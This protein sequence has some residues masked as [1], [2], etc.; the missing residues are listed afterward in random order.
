MFRSLRGVLFPLLFAT[1]TLHAQSNVTIAPQIGPATG[2]QE[3][4]VKG[5]F[6]N[7]PY[8]LIFGSTAV[9]ATRID[10]QT[11]RAITPPH[12]RGRVEVTVFEYA[13]GISTGLTYVFSGEPTGKL[14]RILL[15]VFTPPVFGN[16]GAEFRTD[17]RAANLDDSDYLYMF[18]FMSIGCPIVVLDCTQ[19]SDRGFMFGRGQEVGPD[20]WTPSGTPGTFIYVPTEDVANL[21]L[22]LRAYDVSRDETNFGT[23]IPI[24]FEKDMFVE[25]DIVLLDV[26][27]DDRF[28]NTLRLYGNDDAADAQVT[29]EITPVLTGVAQYREI[30]LLS[31]G[32]AFA[33]AYAEVS[34]LP[35]GVG[36]LR[37]RIFPPVA[38]PISGPW[39][40]PALW[41]FVS[42]TNNETQHITLISPQR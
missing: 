40:P 26:P 18:G 1:A 37:L 35:V 33:P 28:R 14:E 15:P 3:V 36:P 2:G 8:G 5:Q 32:S 13:M 42:V 24:V 11:L 22:Q 9:P 16:H 4:I 41:A 21:S 10:D 29:L 6:G 38:P 31:S 17:L 25:Q 20:E 27:T 19:T 12:P 7:R 34:D 23:E 30:K 39:F